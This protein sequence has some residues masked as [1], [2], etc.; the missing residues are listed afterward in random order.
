MADPG[1][2]REDSRA[3]KQS[4]CYIELWSEKK[5]E[6]ECLRIE[7][8]VQCRSLD[9]ISPQW[10]DCAGSL[11]VGP[12]A[13]AL[14]YADND[15]KGAMLSVG[16][17]QDVADLEALSF[18]DEIASIDLVNSVKVFDELRVKDTEKPVTECSPVKKRG[19]KV[20]QPK[21]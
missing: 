6:G 18:D 1:A 19:K 21:E 20:I 9:S 3:D 13:F 4:G 2:Y 7:G 5:F 12:S 10:G 11:R 16:P 14:V 8:P 17:G 15:F